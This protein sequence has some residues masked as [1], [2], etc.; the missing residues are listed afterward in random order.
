MAILLRLGQP[1][2]GSSRSPRHFV[3]IDEFGKGTE[4]HQATALCAAILRHLDQVLCCDAFMTPSSAV[5]QAKTVQASKL[6]FEPG[7]RWS[8]NPN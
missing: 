8:C 2:G 6:A 5:P 4:D 7:S 1:A 3:C